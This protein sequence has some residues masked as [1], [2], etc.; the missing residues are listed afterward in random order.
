MFS[1]FNPL[2]V[3]I[4]L[5][6]LVSLIVAQILLSRKKMDWRF[7][8]IPPGIIFVLSIVF[9][10]LEM[11]TSEHIQHST[12]EE[13]TVT[14]LARLFIYNVLTILLLGLYSVIRLKK[15]GV[16]FLVILLMLSVIPVFAMCNDG[17]SVQF[18]AILYQI[19]FLHRFDDSRP[20][21]FDTTTK[22]AV[23]PCNFIQEKD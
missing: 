4:P 20:T 6:I 16:K 7:G 2:Y 17:G 14:I 3:L 18:N 22:V 10:V 12:L 11:T 13:N 21:G 15:A 1:F 5:V 19:T 8:F 23:F 9:V